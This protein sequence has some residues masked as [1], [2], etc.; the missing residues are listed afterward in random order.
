MLYYSSTPPSVQQGSIPS[1]PASAININDFVWLKKK[2]VTQM[3]LEQLNYLVKPL[4]KQGQRI[5]VT[6]SDV[7]FLDMAFNMHLS[8]RR[9]SGINLITAAFSEGT[10]NIYR[11]LGMYCLVYFKSDFWS[12]LSDLS[13]ERYKEKVNLRYMLMHDLM[14]LGYNVMLIDA[15]IFFLQDPTNLLPKDDNSWD[16]AGIQVGR[17]I[18]GGLTF[19]NSKPKAKQFIKSVCYFSKVTPNHE[20]YAMRVILE[21]QNFQNVTNGLRLLKI[22]RD[23]VLFLC[24]FPDSTNGHFDGDRSNKVLAHTTCVSTL[25]AKIHAFKESNMW[26]NDRNGYYSNGRR[27]YLTY[28]NNFPERLPQKTLWQKEKLSL[29]NAMLLSDILNRTLI[30]P[31]FQCITRQNKT[32]HCALQAKIVMRCFVKVFSN[33]REHVF[34][35]HSLVPETVKMSQSSIYST[36]SKPSASNKNTKS[37]LSIDVRNIKSWYGNMRESV[38]HL[39]H[40]D[41][42]LSKVSFDA[43]RE[44]IQKYDR[45]IHE[46]SGMKDQRPKY[47]SDQCHL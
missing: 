22:P 45:A 42:E 6:F 31:G 36:L 24:F 40:L 13:S 46:A 41:Q 7:S 2:N 20:Q 19:I 18:N 29:R 30:M 26:L 11:K 12:E 23:H 14:H 32:C 9:V 8:L 25:E 47:P 39:K 43:Y 10:C 37:A 38:L 17:D 21:K 5:A 44:T 28:V 15:D 1:I 16:M 27:K 35:S 3:S 4:A 33:F 34:L